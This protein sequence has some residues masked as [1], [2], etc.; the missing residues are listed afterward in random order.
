MAN[1]RKTRLKI[2]DFHPMHSKDYRACTVKTGPSRMGL[3][4][5][6]LASKH[7]FKYMNTHP[8]D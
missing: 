1:R 3:F 8:V 4:Y 5:F 6:T 7:V 2:E